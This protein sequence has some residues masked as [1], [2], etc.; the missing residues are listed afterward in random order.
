MKPSITIHNYEVHEPEFLAKVLHRASFHQDVY[1]IDV[2]CNERAGKLRSD[3]EGWCEYILRIEYRSGGKL[4][5]GCIE[6]SLG[7]D[8]EFH[9]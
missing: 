8:M 3:P 1:S 9:S 5:I 6:R 4:T 2:Y 7:A